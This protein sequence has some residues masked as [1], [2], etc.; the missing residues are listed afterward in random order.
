[1]TRHGQEVDEAAAAEEVELAQ[2]ALAIGWPADPDGFRA[3]YREL[4]GEPFDL[5]DDAGRNSR[6]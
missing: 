4:G 5:G 6:R 3:E 2:P 1:M